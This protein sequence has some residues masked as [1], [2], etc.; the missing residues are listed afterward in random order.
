MKVRTQLR[1]S[2]VRVEAYL[3]TTVSHPDHERYGQH[4][5]Q[6]EVN[7]LIKPSEEGLDL[8]HEWL[9]TNGVDKFDYSPA[10]DW[11]N[12]YISVEDAERLLDTEYSVFQH[13]DGSYLVRTSHA[14]RRPN[15][16]A[17]LIM[18]VAATAI[19]QPVP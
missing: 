2:R 13:E 15:R 10:K 19:T 8:V 16:S 4:L 1:R 18:K 14:C 7:E 12:I 9:I 11:V 17:W 3:A 6:E 5:S